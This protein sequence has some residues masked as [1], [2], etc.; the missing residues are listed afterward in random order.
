MLGVVAFLCATP[1]FGQNGQC[2]GYGNGTVGYCSSGGCFQQ[3]IQLPPDGNEVVWYRY[4][5]NCCG[6]YVDMWVK[7]GGANC[8]A[9][10]AAEK[11]SSMQLLLGEGIHLMGRDCVGRPVIYA[12][13]AG[14]VAQTSA[15]ASPIDLSQP[16]K[17]F[18]RDLFRESSREAR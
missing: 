3:F 18:V 2:E 13:P 7:S 11:K 17:R 5:V 16:D 12:S 9:P 8:F 10:M 1:S 15:Q 6:H 14:L 4:N